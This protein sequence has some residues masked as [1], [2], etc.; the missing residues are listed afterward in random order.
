MTAHPPK[1]EIF[2]VPSATNTDPKGIVRA[3]D[4]Y[5]TT[6]FGLYLARP[7][8]GR[9]QF[10]F[11][12]S[13][14]LPALGLRIT[15]FWFTEGHE[16]DQDFYLDVVSVTTENGTWTV[17]DLYLDL[18]L[19]CGRGVEVIDTDELVAAACEGLVTRQQAEWAFERVYATVDALAYHHYDLAAWMSTVDIEL[20]WLRHPAHPHPP[21][22]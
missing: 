2:D 21:I 19:R 7:A 13:W 11:L 9:T 8:P 3:V 15:D 22:G 4:E 17:T 1:R 6:P 10:H 16:R 18:V 5:R 14:L 12:E 20:S